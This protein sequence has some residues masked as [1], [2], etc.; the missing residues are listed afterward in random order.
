MEERESIWAVPGP[1]LVLYRIVFS[2]L[3]ISSVSVVT[4]YEIRI[5]TNDGPIETFMAIGH[6]SS[7]F[8]VLSAGITIVF[9]ESLYM[10]AE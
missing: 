9:V 7:P 4:R 5:R 2:V 6:G 3:V 10:I 1:V 8:I